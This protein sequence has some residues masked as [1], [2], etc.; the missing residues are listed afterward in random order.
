VH[1]GDWLTVALPEGPFVGV[2]ASL[3]PEW[4]QEYYVE[5]LEA[6]AEATLRAG[7][8]PDAPAP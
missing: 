7:W 4:E 8:D 3:A 2:V 1:L 6:G 5:L